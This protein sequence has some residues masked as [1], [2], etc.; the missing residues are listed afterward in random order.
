MPIYEYVCPNCDFKFELLRSLN[1][2]NAAALCPRCHS[3]AKRIFSC[4]NA[5]SEGHEGTPAA[6]AGSNPCSTCSATSCT[7]CRN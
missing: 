1:Q 2:T 3:D 6:I 7:A 4:F 5:F